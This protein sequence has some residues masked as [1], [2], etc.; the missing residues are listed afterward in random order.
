MIGQGY[1]CSMLVRGRYRWR[2]WLRGRLPWALVDLVP[3]GRRD[4][5]A[6]EWHRADEATDRC[7]HCEV[8]VRAHEPLPVPD[9][10]ELR[11]SLRAQ[12]QRGSNAARAALARL[13]EDDRHLAGSAPAPE[14]APRARA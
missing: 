2:T 4:C 7:Y 11:A 1:T 14:P 8:G 10:P 6:H 3:K 12:A 5:G 9:D 13:E